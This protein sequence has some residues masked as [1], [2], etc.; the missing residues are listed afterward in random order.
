MTG[1]VETMF[2][3]EQIKA[4]GGVLTSEDLERYKNMR[5]VLRYMKRFV[6]KRE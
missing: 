3:E 4:G 6:Q 2:H 5:A 1:G